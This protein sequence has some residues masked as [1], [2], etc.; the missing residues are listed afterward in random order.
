MKLEGT[1][2]YTVMVSGQSGALSYTVPVALV[3]N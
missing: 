3:V 1:V 2:A